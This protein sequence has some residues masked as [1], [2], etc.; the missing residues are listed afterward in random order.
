MI[1]TATSENKE[2]NI[3]GFAISTICDSS[4][5]DHI[6][7]IKEKILNLCENLA[8]YDTEII[9]QSLKTITKIIFLILMKMPI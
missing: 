5:K 6:I 3:P 2:I 1:V 9:C 4:F 7:K 8:V